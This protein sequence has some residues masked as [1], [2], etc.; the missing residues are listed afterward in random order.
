MT[1]GSIRLDSRSL[2]PV[3]EAVTASAI[4]ASARVAR[5]AVRDRFI[6]DCCLEKCRRDLLSP[7]PDAA[8]HH[9]LSGDRAE[10]IEVFVTAAAT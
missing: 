9:F 4:P 2:F 7:D 3:H 5:S 1:P 10:A 8:L 6:A